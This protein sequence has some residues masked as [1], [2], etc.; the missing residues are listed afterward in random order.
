[1]DAPEAD[2][3]IKL[4]KIS[5]DLLG[6][7]DRSLPHFLWKPD[8]HGGTRVRSR[9][10]AKETWRL[11][12][13]LLD[14][15]QELPQ[16]L[17]PYLPKWIPLLAEAF[18]K[19]LQTRHRGK[20][21]SS[22]S[23]LLVSVEFAICKI[24]YTFCKIRGE[25]VIV[26]F[27][28]VEAKYLELLLLAIEESEQA[29]ADDVVLGK[30]SWEERYVVLLWL[31]HLLLAPFD[32]STISSVDLQDI[33]APDIPGMVWPEN[34]PAITVRMIPLAIKYIG[35]PG[36]EREAAK[37]LLVRMSIR[38]DMQQLGVLKS[39]VDWSLASL[40]PRK[41]Q[42][43][44]ATYFYLGVLSFLAGVLRA[45]S[46]TSDMNPY[47]ST[48]F[49]AIHA[50]SVGEDELSKTIVSFALARKMILKVI[51]S[52]VVLRLRQT[53]Q[54]MASTELTETA[55][56]YLLESVSDN[57][58]P[59]RLAASKSL[60]IITLKL[61]PDMASQVVEAV[62]ESL[63]RNVLWKKPAGGKPVRDLSAVNNLEWHGLMLTLSHLL[64][65][66]SPPT[67][68]LS[69]II[70]ALLLGISFEQRSMSGGSVGTNVRDAACFGIW[71]LARRYTSDE[72]LAIPTHSV[73]AAKAHPATSSILQV[74]GTELV[75]TASLDPAGNIRRGASA[76][77]QELIGRHPD[78]VEQGIWV[79]QT[80]DYH[81]VA[82]RSRAIEEVA[83]NATRL[84]NQY[85]EAIIDTLLGWR[86]I[87]D[88]DA[89][90]R[91]VSSAAFGTLTFE[92]SDTKSGDSLAR[93]KTT[94]KLLTDRLKTLQ[95]RQ[96]EERHGLLLCFTAVLDKFPAL[97]DAGTAQHDSSLIHE[98]LST[99]SDVLENLQSTAYRKPE[100]L[101]EA[102]SRLVVSVLP[103]LH[104]A[105]LGVDS[106]ETLRPG[107][108]LLHPDNS[109]GYLNLVSALDSCDETRSAAVAQLISSLRAIVPTWLNRSEQETAEPTAVASL[110]LLI[111]SGPADRKALLSEWAET[112]Q[113]RP[114]SRT[115]AHGNGYFSA[116]TIAQPLVDS[117]DDVASQAI[118]ER[119]AWDNEIDTRVAILQSLK[120]SSVLQNKPLTFLQLIAEGLNDYTTNAR[121]DVGSHVRVHALRAVRALWNKLDEVVTQGEW[122]EE[123]VRVL[124][125]GAL[126]LSAEKLD[127]VRPE[128]Q[129]AVALVL[130]EGHSKQFLELTFSSKAY[131]QSLLNLHVGGRLRPLLLDVAKGD[132]SAW[133]TEL[134]SGFV[135]SADT[136]NEDL[137]IASR[138][139]LSDF[140]E[141]SPEKLDLI[142]QALLQN[143]KTRQG[144][145][146]VIV[147]TLEIIAF[148]FHVQLF[149][150]S[151][152]NLRSL[153]L[154]TQKAGYKTGNVRKLEACTK[155][156][157]GVASMTD[158]EGAEAG[159]QEARK[160]L[161]ALLYH[162]WP[163]VRSMVVDELWGVLGDQEETAEKLKGVDWGQAGKPQIKT[164][165]EELR[166]S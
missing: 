6:D 72:L 1:M 52:V 138:A 144:Q 94:V 8:G 43:L 69:D 19:H 108:E 99:V 118:L 65:R 31:S 165:V 160:R 47:L 155:V 85:G 129:A 9:V 146:R 133:M 56:G 5:A 26:R 18:L 55:I 79:V 166:L 147:P 126:R 83:V 156:Y 73:F 148:L 151:S 48:I 121:G 140:C 17:D 92:L 16:L 39:L 68:Q 2:I 149:Q 107:Q 114:T 64:Y 51:R 150:K 28:N 161:G 122:A 71:A 40:R 131:F 59:V 76:A 4:Q 36:K 98:I 3:D 7:F 145:D 45:S 97:F 12:N 112:V 125:F 53:T 58:T 132:P 50:I 127:R 67:E 110:V 106:Q 141:A 152:V 162:P 22:R 27:L 46:D 81:S 117:S 63:N 54:D 157:S 143:L 87:G 23:K 25:K 113:R 62:L 120:K 41:D 84:S 135:A 101:A 91:R 86:G 134:M 142:C 159:V 35:T 80:V 109:S 96:V 44:Q 57:D 20:T 139:A 136:G 30:W 38:R 90:S 111:F 88:L 105:V 78:T 100:L 123:S 103:I 66:R 82:R 70:H 10:R 75:V 104:V 130:Q 158:Q 49:Y 154:Q 77:L 29:S 21:L 124:F 128:A 37:A 11:T 32:L 34:L 61:D 15:F 164:A 24:L 33:T 74:L 13:T 119:W 60:S 89:A 163:K 116:L 115:A 153:C 14:P 102:A 93:F 42:P 137:V 95:A